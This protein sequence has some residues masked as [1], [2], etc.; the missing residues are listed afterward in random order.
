MGASRPT[1][2]IMES[3]IVWGPFERPLLHR[4]IGHIHEKPAYGAENVAASM[5][6]ISM[7]IGVGQ[8]GT[9]YLATL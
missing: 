2:Y 1:D 6:P 9:L 7:S 3:Y 4:G 8:N 5:V